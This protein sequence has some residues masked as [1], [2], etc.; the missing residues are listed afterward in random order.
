MI[1]RALT[2]ADRVAQRIACLVRSDRLEA[3]GD[4]ADWR[5]GEMRLAAHSPH[6]R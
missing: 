6:A 4:M 1:A 2:A 5:L 3:A